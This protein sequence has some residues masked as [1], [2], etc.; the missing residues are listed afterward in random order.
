LVVTTSKRLESKGPGRPARWP[1]RSTLRAFIRRYEASS[2]ASGRGAWGGLR[3]AGAW[4]RDSLTDQAVIVGGTRA[5]TCT[6][7]RCKSLTDR[8]GAVTT[9]NRPCKAAAC[10][11]RSRLRARGRQVRARAARPCL[12]LAGQLCL[13]TSSQKLPTVKQMHGRSAYNIFTRCSDAQD[14]RMS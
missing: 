5:Q 6:V 13:D 14:R 3:R 11:C 10:M 4:P 9:A 12:P 8:Y 7:V 1:G 2:F